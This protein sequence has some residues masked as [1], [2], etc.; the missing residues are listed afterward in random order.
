MMHGYFF[1]NKK[2]VADYIIPAGWKV[3]PVF[4]AVHLDPS[5]HADALHFDPS[6][7][8]VLLPH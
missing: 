2:I 4:S 3:L 6:R 1:F 7:W 5:L 8:Q